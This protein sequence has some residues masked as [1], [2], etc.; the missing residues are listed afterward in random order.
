MQ[1]QF[2][3]DQLFEN[4][5]RTAP[6]ILTRQK[7]Y[8]LTGGLISV[9]TLANLDSDGAGISPRLRIGQKVAYP[10]QAAIDFLKKRSQLF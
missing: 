6:E 5:S 1:D 3:I 9:K 4:L 8:E 10:K 7:L 2:T